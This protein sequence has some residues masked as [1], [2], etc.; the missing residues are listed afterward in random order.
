[1]QRSLLQQEKTPLMSRLCQSVPSI[2]LYSSMGGKGHP[3]PLGAR[4]GAHPGQIT[5]SSKGK[6]LE[7][8]Y[9]SVWN[10]HLGIVLSCW[11]EEGAQ[12]DGRN[13]GRTCKLPTDKALGFRTQRFEETARTTA[14]LFLTNLLLKT[15]QE[16]NNSVAG[17]DTIKE[18]QA[19][20]A[21][22]IKVM[23]IPF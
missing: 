3:S 6:Y 8:N 22:A 17:L 18:L 1:M 14:P 2:H 7:T 23:V 4:G 11:F 15:W 13:T 5:S 10:S 20:L 9:Y 19:L 21:G 12:Y 16:S